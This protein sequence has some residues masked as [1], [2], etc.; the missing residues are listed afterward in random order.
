MR[1][2]I[3]GKIGE[4]VISDAT[5]QRFATAE[6]KVRAAG[7]EVFNPTDEEWQKHLRLRYPKECVQQPRGDKVDYYS[8]VLLRDMMVLA[9]CDAIYMLPDY[10]DSR[11]ARAE[12]AFACAAQKIIIYDTGLERSGRMTVTDDVVI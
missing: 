6:A 9:T 2:Y 1:V 10:P 12:C 3:S 11:G 4:A 5:R 8:Y 7:H